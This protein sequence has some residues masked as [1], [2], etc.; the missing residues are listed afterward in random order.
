MPGGSFGL[1]EATEAACRRGLG[2]HGQGDPVR[3]RRRGY[4]FALHVALSSCGR[5][6]RSSS[7]CTARSSSST[8]RAH[9]CSQSPSCIS[10]FAVGPIITLDRDAASPAALHR[11]AGEAGFRR[12]GGE[13]VGRCLRG[14]RCCWRGRADVCR[15]YDRHRA[16]AVLDSP[17][18]WRERTPT[19]RP[20][21]GGDSSEILRFCSWCRRNH[22]AWPPPSE[23]PEQ[24]PGLRRIPIAVAAR[25]LRGRRS[26]SPRRPHPR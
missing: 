15:R 7:C 21:F 4:G 8:R 26:G 17:I 25:R 22:P 3:D 24:Y 6:R 14:H 19:G 23:S 10:A 12:G 5:A 13:C 1:P 18:A 2:G 20:L 11:A 9:D 16:L